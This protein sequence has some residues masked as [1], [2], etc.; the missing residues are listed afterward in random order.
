MYHGAG[1]EG[2][3]EEY[4][5]PIKAAAPEGLRFLL[6]SATLPQ[7]TYHQLQ[8]L[9]PGLRAAFGPGLHRTAAG[10][11]SLRVVV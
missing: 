8:D 11:S 2:N 9:F 5:A 6:V 7:H 1:G 10:K 3:Y 4:I